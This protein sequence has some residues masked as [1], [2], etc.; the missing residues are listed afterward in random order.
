MASCFIRGQNFCAAAP[1]FYKKTRRVAATTLLS[2]VF[3]LLI[4]L[5]GCASDKTPD[6]LD[7]GT[8][9]GVAADGQRE[10]RR[11]TWPHAASGE[12]PRY[13][14]AG[15]L[16]GEENFHSAGGADKTFADRIV[17]S[18]RW[19]VG[20]DS[21]G[22]RPVT[23][24]RPQSGVVDVAG[25]RI[26]VTDTS[27]QAVY[28]FDHKEG[29]LKLWQNATRT[30]RF[31]GP[32]GIAL[33]AAGEVYVADA[34]LGYVT[35]LNQQGDSLGVIGKGELKRPIG[36]VFDAASQQLYVADTH[37]HNIKVFGGEGQLLR[38][39]GQRGEGPGEFNFPTYLALA[40]GELYVADTMNARIQVLDAATGGPKRII[41]ERGLNIG[42]LVRPKGVA[43]DGAGNVYV[44]ESYHDHLLVFNRNGEFLLP[45]GGTGD[46]IGQFYLPS[47]VWTDA[48]NR[49]F[50]ADMFNAR[51]ALFQ[52]LGGAPSAEAA[53]TSTPPA[54]PNAGIGG[55]PVAP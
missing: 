32:T 38:T 28:V 15:E 29:Q 48:H 39:L 34:E 8:G 26:L 50:V 41:G 30:Q 53:G 6:V 4:L 33:G 51:V 7:F 43:L 5:A 25:Q 46:G 36:L 3:C 16:Y 47:G 14:Y 11:V 31:V 2:S 22:Y 20:L 54:L 27:R 55:S 45:I 13:Q 1:R 12:T 21:A 18:L 23:L 42:N 44:V 17:A 49:I 9:P 24:R 10:I 40:Q 37:G 19:L 52:F 35:R